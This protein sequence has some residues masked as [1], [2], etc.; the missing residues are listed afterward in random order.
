MEPDSQATD[1]AM[2]GQ[3][4]REEWEIGVLHCYRE[5]NRVGKWIS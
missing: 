3:I 2:E 5:T 1:H 4:A